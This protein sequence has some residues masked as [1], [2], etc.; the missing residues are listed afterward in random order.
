M[1]IA[2]SLHNSSARCRRKVLQAPARASPCPGTSGAHL[3]FLVA[4]TFFSALRLPMADGKSFRAPVPQCADRSKPGRGRLLRRARLDPVSLR[5]DGVPPPD[6]FASS[7]P[8]SK[9]SVMA[10]QLHTNAPKR[11]HSPGAQQITHPTAH[12]SHLGS[13]L[14]CLTKVLPG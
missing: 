1:G 7:R 6:R 5:T 2:L 9:G 14:L 12:P 3:G 10:C 11:T 4:R 8:G 13:T